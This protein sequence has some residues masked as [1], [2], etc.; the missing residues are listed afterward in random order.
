MKI[1][2]MVTADF[3]A[4]EPV[5]NKLNIL[6]VFRNIAAESFPATHRRMF[7]VVKIGGKLSSSDDS[8]RLQMSIVSNSGDEMTRVESTFLMPPDSSAEHN[9]LFELNGLVFRKPGNY[10]FNVNIDDG[11]VTGSTVVSVFQRED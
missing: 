2:M 6:G 5:T 1:L 3:A 11:Q 4:V 8:H 9:A 7:F 10:F